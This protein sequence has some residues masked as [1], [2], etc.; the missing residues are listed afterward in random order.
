MRTLLGLFSQEAQYR[1]IRTH[2]VHK[3]HVHSYCARY[4][5]GED[6]LA[7]CA[8]AD[9]PACLM[10]RRMLEQMLG[11]SKQVRRLAASGLRLRLSGGCSGRCLGRFTDLIRA[12]LKTQHGTL[13]PQY[14]HTNPQQNP[15]CTT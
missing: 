3:A 14:Q 10:M 11:L 1:V 5:A 12:H 7:L 2:H 13:S 4:R 6:V 9:F 8:A 15:R